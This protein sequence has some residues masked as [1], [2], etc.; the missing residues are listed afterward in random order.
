LL[1]QRV[2]KDMT[3][4][5]ECLFKDGGTLLNLNPSNC[6]LCAAEYG[7]SDRIDKEESEKKKC[8]CSNLR[9]FW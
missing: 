2:E 6:V 4:V 3:L 9:D 1:L 8:F 7:F 5:A